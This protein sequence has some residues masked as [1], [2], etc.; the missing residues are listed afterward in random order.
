MTAINCP[1]CQ[2]PFQ[3]SVREGILIDTCTQCR[4]VWLDRGELEKLLAAMR[5]EVG[6]TV[7]A[8]PA[9]AAASLVVA[10]PQGYVPPQQP[11]YPPTQ[12]SHQGYQQPY[13]RDYDDDDYRRHGGGRYYKKSKMERLFDIFD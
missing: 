1:V 13:R 9:A 8:Q 5:Q 4:G 7:P 6:N 12:H 2:A 10:Q 3:E 11:H